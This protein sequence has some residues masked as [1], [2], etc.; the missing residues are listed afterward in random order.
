MN[1]EIKCTAYLSSK[2]LPLIILRFLLFDR[3]NCGCSACFFLIKLNHLKRI[4]PVTWKYLFTRILLREWSLFIL[5]CEWQV[6]AYMCEVVRHG[7]LWA[8]SEKR[9]MRSVNLQKFCE[10]PRLWCQSTN[11][12]SQY[13]WKRHLMEIK[14]C[15]NA[16]VCLPWVIELSSILYLFLQILYPKLCCVLGWLNSYVHLKI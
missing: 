9:G 14:T 3:S 12:L 7:L 15:A 8:K 2:I 5:Q 11:G 6:R 4:A 16:T 1:G 10:N 13:K